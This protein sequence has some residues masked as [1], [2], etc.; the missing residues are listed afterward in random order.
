MGKYRD[1]S[2][3]QFLPLLLAL[4]VPLCCCRM[5]MLVSLLP[6]GDAPEASAQIASAIQPSCCHQNHAPVNDDAP[7]SGEHGDELP[8]HCSGN[9][10]LKGLT[11]TPDDLDAPL[12]IDL[13][14]VLTWHDAIWEPH[15]LVEHPHAAIDAELTPCRS[16]LHQHC[17]L[18]I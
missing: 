9:C 1:P 4:C 7:A 10:C 16:L 12:A 6:G 14:D 18:R 17:A 11:P 8:R 15:N 5:S 13:A 2:R 3:W